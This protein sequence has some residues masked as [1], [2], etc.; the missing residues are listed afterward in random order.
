MLK[1]SKNTRT[2]AWLASAALLVAACAADESVAPSDDGGGDESSSSTGSSSGGEGNGS[3]SA[4]GGDAQCGPGSVSQDDPCEVCVVEQCA[5]EAYACC[6][7]EGCLDIIDCARQTGCDGINCY[8]PDAC[9][10][11]IDAAGGPGVATQYAMPLGDCAA[12]K[13]TEACDY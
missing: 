5:T 10:N 3:S 13:C 8:S 11:E 7:Q 1:T 4:A 9:Q 6:M 12:S 2:A